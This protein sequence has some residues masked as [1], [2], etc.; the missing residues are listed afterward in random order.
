MRGEKCV[1]CGFSVAA[2]HRV[3]DYNRHSWVEVPICRRCLLSLGYRGEAKLYEQMKI[4]E[5]LR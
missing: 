5:A 1:R 2:R 4:A 3:Y